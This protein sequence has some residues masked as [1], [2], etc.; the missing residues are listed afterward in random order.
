MGEREYD[1]ED[2][3]LEY[4]A[5]VIR[6]VEKMVNT[7][8]GNHVGGQLLRSGTSPLFNHGEAQAAE[9]PR[10]FIHKMK[11]C[12]KEL[13]ESHRAL[14]LVRKVPLINDPSEVDPFLRET[15]ELIR[16]FVTSIRTAQKNK[17]RED[18]DDGYGA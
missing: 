2:R 10:D 15:D 14:R 7:R 8:A 3:L 9:S 12:L 5:S 16:I 18:A 1:L 13:R 17:V 6:L 11:I 4:A